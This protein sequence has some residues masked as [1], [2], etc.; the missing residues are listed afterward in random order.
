MS[1]L[2]DLSSASDDAG[3]W[4]AQALLADPDAPAA[5]RHVGGARWI[6]PSGE[7]VDQ[8]VAACPQA[9]VADR[10]AE[11][12]MTAGGGAYR[13][14]E[15]GVWRYAAT[16]QPV[17]GAQDL[18]LR[19]LYPDLEI[20]GSGEQAVV[21]VP[22]ALARECDDLAWIRDVAE[23]PT[24]QLDGQ[25]AHRGEPPTPG[26][27]DMWPV[28]RAAWDARA[29]QPLGLLAAEL[30]AER[31]LDLSGVAARCAMAY[32]TVRDYHARNTLPTPQAHAGGSPLWARPIIDQ[33]HR[34][35]RGPGRPRPDR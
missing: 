10:G 35:R 16:G 9:R 1:W 20:V 32:Q 11:A 31:M 29:M 24:S 26:G 15:H 23:G 34:H 6:T 28:P 19:Q 4:H 5:T 27:T 8:V 2:I 25:R 14:D 18:T 7:L 22:D 21:L 12:P 3:W 13:R 30:Q 17:P 33:W